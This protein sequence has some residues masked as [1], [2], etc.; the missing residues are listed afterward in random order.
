MI[1]DLP[2][3]IVDDLPEEFGD[4]QVVSAH[5]N[6]KEAEQFIKYF[7]GANMDSYSCQYYYIVPSSRV[8]WLLD[9]RVAQIEA[10]RRMQRRKP[11][12]ISEEERKRRSTQGKKMAPIMH[13]ARKKKAAQKRL[14]ERGKEVF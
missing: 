13:E 1:T 6:R 4:I 7:K 8:S 12:K 9:K 10:R 11:P 3:L 5:R 2:Y 14:M